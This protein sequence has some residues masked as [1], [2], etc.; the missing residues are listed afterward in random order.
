MRIV[1]R[2]NQ[3][4]VRRK[5]RIITASTRDVDH[6]FSARVA[7][8]QISD[9][10]GSLVQF[11]GSVDDR[12]QLSSGNQLAEQRE[13]WLVGFSDEH[14]CLLTAKCRLRDCLHRSS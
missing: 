14:D 9:G 12:F 13:V 1:S 6:N 11:A 4:E 8:F 5:T 10:F 2:A 7:F 3:Y